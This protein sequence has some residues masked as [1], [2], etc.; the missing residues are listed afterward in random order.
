VWNL[1]FDIIAQAGR[2]PPGAQQQGDLRNFVVEA[3]HRIWVHVAMDR[4]TG[5]VLDLQTE[6]VFE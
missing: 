3:E 4:L 6:E 2:F 1:L 5:E